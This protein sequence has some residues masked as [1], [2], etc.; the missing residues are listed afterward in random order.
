MIIF[1]L[2][3]NKIENTVISV[4][5]I[6]NWFFYFYI[7]LI[8]EFWYFSLIWLKDLKTLLGI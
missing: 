3:F 7:L 2:I 6:Y 5:W 8:L 4:E 1:I